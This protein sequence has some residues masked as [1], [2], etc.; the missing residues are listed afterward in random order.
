M[1]S[2]IFRFGHSLIPNQF[3][4]LDKNFDSINKPTTLQEAFF[5]RLLVDQYG[6]ET[7]MFGLMGNKSEEVR[8]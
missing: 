1:Y 8:L 3:D 6:I 7:V 4:M 5:N 2:E